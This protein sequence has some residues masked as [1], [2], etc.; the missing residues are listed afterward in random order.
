[1]D[2]QVRFELKKIN[3]TEANKNNKAD[4]DKFRKS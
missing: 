2:R 4:L 1:M 3:V